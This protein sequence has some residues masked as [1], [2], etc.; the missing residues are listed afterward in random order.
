[1]L[2][3]SVGKRAAMAEHIG[4]KY[5]AIIWVGVF[6]KE[7]DIYLFIDGSWEIACELDLFVL[8]W[9]I[10]KKSTLLSCHKP[11]MGHAV[12]T[13]NYKNNLVRN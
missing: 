7:A 5:P 12:F 3:L 9:R 6:E 1:M 2:G 13:P 4:N 10:N 11:I 8:F